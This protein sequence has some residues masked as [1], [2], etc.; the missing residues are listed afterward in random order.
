[1]LRQIL[2]MWFRHDAVNAGEQVEVGLPRAISTTARAGMR[3][4]SEN[5]MMCDGKLIDLPERIVSI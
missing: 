4:L 1:M 3:N 5:M 2:S